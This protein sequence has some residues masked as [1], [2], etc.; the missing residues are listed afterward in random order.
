MAYK[1]LIYFSKKTAIL[2]DLNNKLL[3]G[4]RVKP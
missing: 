4:W 3:L 2:Q 1:T